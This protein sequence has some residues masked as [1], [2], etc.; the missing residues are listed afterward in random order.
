VV[1]AEKCL[2]VRGK[3]G[4]FCPLF[5]RKK[6]RKS[7]QNTDRVFSEK[8]WFCPLFERKKKS[9]ISAEKPGLFRSIRNRVFSGLFVFFPLFERTRYLPDISDRIKKFGKYL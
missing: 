6:S 9:A 3:H 4:N 5:P 8:T 2:F 7:A 1:S